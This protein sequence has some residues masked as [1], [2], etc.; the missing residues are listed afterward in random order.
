MTH[1]CET[2]CLCISDIDCGSEWTQTTRVSS[3]LE[4][5]HT[6]GKSVLVAL[7]VQV[8]LICQVCVN[9]AL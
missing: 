2:V 3:V 4:K 5:E 7:G 6:L 8:S 9:E 1:S